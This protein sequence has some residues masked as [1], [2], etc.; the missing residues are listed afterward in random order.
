MFLMMI[1]VLFI[2]GLIIYRVLINDKNFDLGENILEF[3]AH[4]ILSLIV[5][6]GCYWAAFDSK[7][8]D[9]EI[10][11]SM[12][13]TKYRD[14]VSCSHSYSCN[15]HMVPS[16]T[17]KN[18][19]YSQ[20]C[21]TCYE[22]NHDYDWVVKT[23]SG[24]HTNIDRVDRQGKFEP[25][26]WTSVYKGQ[27]YAATHSFDNY[28]LLNP[29]NVILGEKGD[30]DKWKLLIPQYPL[31]IYDY[32]GHDPVI[33]EGVPGIKI[34]EW[35]WIIREQNKV[36]GTKKQVNIVVILVPTNDASYTY[37]LRDAWKGGKKNDV[38]VILGSKNGHSI[39]FTGIVSWTTNAEFKVSLKNEIDA[40]GTLDRRDEISQAIGR[41][42]DAKFD[43]LHMKTMKYLTKDFQLSSGA[44][45][46]T[47]IGLIILNVGIVIGF[48]IQEN[49]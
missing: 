4:F 2:V 23:T 44:L 42:V 37:A 14:T 31:S 25:S 29:N 18:V 15:C 17:G 41:N 7:V 26:R 1:P 47:A 12:V 43:R 13:S 11:N 9:T 46:G 22:H 10:W 21:D 3:V 16:G 36:L 8:T 33:N 45:I 35:N 6:G 28:I 20:E 38:I 34:D 40:I 32:Y 19:T 49:D 27:P 39:D 24:E 5:I 30:A 48:K